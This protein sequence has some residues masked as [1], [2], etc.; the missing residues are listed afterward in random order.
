MGVGSSGAG[1]SIFANANK[2]SGNEKGNGTTWT[3]TTLDAGNQ[4][5]LLSGWDTTLKGAQANADKVVAD[6]GRDLTLQSLQDTDNYG[7]RGQIY[8]S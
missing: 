2:G 8:F 4:A 1:L 6:V 3:E 7:E 5:S